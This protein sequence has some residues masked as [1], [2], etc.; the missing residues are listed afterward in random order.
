MSKLSQEKKNQITLVVVGTL[1]VCLGLWYVVIGS[2]SE[3]LTKQKDEISKLDS[4]IYQAESRIRRARLVQSELE[5]LQARL[6]EREANL[7]PVEQLNGRK[8]LYDKLVNFIKD[9]YDVQ[10]T[11]LSNEPVLDNEQLLLPRFDYS[12]AVYRVEVHAFYHELGRFLADFENSFPLMRI[13]KISVWPIATAK[14][15]VSGL[16]VDTPEE[17]LNSQEI[18]RLNIQLDVVLLYRPHGS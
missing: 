16:V 11:N 3:Q 18:E 13:Q 15:S 5:E 1:A 10:L 6:E 14:E 4:K 8:W 2:Q 12:A 17:I 7:I 9:Q